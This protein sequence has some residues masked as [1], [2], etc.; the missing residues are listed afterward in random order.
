MAFCVLQFALILKNILLK[1]G[2][3]LNAALAIGWQRNGAYSVRWREKGI[4]KI[5]I[6]A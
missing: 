5:V 2:A 6:R 3:K 4:R 1:T